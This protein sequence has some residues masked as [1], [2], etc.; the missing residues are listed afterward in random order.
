VKRPPPGFGWDPGKRGR[1]LRE[2]GIDF[3]DVAV[4]FDDVQTRFAFDRFDSWTGEARSRAIGH[5][6]DGRLVVVAFA[7]RTDERGDELIWIISARDAEKHERKA[8]EEDPW[9]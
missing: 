8:Y 1:T 4:L 6:K 9:P 2:R 7:E 5:M 3:Y